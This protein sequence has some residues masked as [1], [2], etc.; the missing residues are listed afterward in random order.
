[1]RRPTLLPSLDSAHSAH[2]ARRIAPICLTLLLTLPLTACLERE[3]ELALA[4]APMPT[5]T[6]LNTAPGP[7]AARPTGSFARIITLDGLPPQALRPPAGENDGA[8]A[9]TEHRPLAA[10]AGGGCSCGLRHTQAGSVG[11]WHLISEEQLP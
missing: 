3:G 8:S 6:P 11:R 1:M 10:A 9:G 7:D 5:S 2:S 4:P